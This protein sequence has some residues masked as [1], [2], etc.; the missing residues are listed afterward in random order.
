MTL[1]LKGECQV[2]SLGLSP[3]PPYITS[4]SPGCQACHPELF[5]AV[6]NTEDSTFPIPSGPAI[7]VGVENP[8]KPCQDLCLKLFSFVRGENQQMFLK[9]NLINQCR[10]VG[11]SR[12]FWQLGWVQILHP[13]L[14]MHTSA[15]TPNN[16]PPASL[17]PTTLAITTSTPS[18]EVSPDCAHLFLSP[19][20]Q[21]LALSLCPM[22]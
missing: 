1:C 15:H 18:P 19:L 17:H 21:A 11:A 5:L 2:S 10:S 3:N 7:R 8:S 9:V 13:H 20:A 14:C 12:P 4:T 6:I 22:S 16:L